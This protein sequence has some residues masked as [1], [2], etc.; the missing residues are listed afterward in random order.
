MAAAI[1][2]PCPECEDKLKVPAAARGKKVRCKSCG[3]TF[4]VPTGKPSV[5][6]EDDGKPYGVTTLNLLP[7]CPECANEMADE[8]AI[9]CLHC[10]YNTV[11]RKRAET[12]MVYELT[13]ADYFRWLM[14]GVLCVVCVLALIGFDAWY[15]M[16][17]PKMVLGEWFEFIGSGACTLWVVI[18]SLF[19][20]YFAGK[21][22]FRRLILNPT[23]PEIEKHERL[24]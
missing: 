1:S 2:I 13:G 22:A 24:T 21:F 3:H 17:V 18:N 11:T 7:R 8:T 6:D 10:G 20:I 5:P 23:P 12:R 9:I 16:A 4:T 19:G 14:P 15:I